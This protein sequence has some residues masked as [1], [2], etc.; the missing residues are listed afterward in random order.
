MIR[1]IAKFSGGLLAF[2][3]FIAVIVGMTASVALAAPDTNEPTVRI[4]LMTKQFGLLVESNGNY[5]IVNVDT[6]K[7]QGEYS[8][9]IK[10]RIGLRE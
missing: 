5:E 3:C 1:S 4:G 6:N 9:S 7:V 8:G 2:V 10:T